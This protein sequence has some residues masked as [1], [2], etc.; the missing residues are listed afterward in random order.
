MNNDEYSELLLLCTYSRSMD[1]FDDYSNFKGRE[2]D[3]LN[4]HWFMHGRINRE[5]SRLDCVKIIRMLYGTFLVNKMV[6]G[7]CQDESII[8][9]DV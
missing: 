7:R 2:P 1:I 8:S 4:R 9:T 3:N 6:E 5:L